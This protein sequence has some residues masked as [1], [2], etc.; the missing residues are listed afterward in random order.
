MISGG[1]LF[2]ASLL[3]A[4]AM[5][6][7]GAAAFAQDYDDFSRGRNL[8]VRD[9]ARPDF[10][11]VGIDLAP[12]L[13][14]PRLDVT[15]EFDDNIL[16]T[17]TDARS[18]VIFHIK[19]EAALK[20]QFGRHEL[21]LSAYADINRYVDTGTE[22]T[23]DYGAKASGRLDILHWTA[24]TGGFSYDHLTE[25]R[26]AQNTTVN[27]VS[28]VEYGLMT[29]DL[30]GVQQFSFFK[31]TLSGH[32]A[33]Y[34]YQ[35]G[36]DA[37]G[38]TVFEQDRNLSNWEESGRIDYALTPDKSIYIS[39]TLNQTVYDLV[40]PAVSLN[41][42]STGF[43]LLGGFNFDLTNLLA[44]DIG[45]GYFR[46]DYDHLSGQNSGGFA[47]NGDIKWFPTQLTTVSLTASR[48]MQDATVGISAGY[49]STGG[50]LQIDHEL[51]RW[52]ILTATASYNNDDYQGIDRTDDRWSAGLSATYLLNRNVGLTAGYLH[53]A[54]RSAGAARFVN[55]EDNK[56]SLS[57]VLQQ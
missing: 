36:V 12:F 31:F 55:F 37:L 38:N 46:Q 35:D 5:A 27:T 51:R 25:S 17:E 29:A 16:A 19:P 28:P 39:G 15:T 26:A 52:L 22:D 18:D 6:G 2:C 13:L 9:R 40:P 23:T 1:R 56:W 43:T 21:D 42:N 41:R 32:Y 50:T 8:A 54:Q 30:A 45:L 4:V 34:D 11:A 33:N 48:R 47:L 44:G 53:T 57:L 7:V 14:L 10:D 3:A 24:L 20:S 49:I